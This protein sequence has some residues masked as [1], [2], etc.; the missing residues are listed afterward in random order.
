MPLMVIGTNA[1]PHR[2]YRL[3]PDPK[4]R[5]PRASAKQL[6]PACL[7]ALTSEVV[8]TAGSTGPRKEREKSVTGKKKKK[9]KKR[10]VRYKYFNYMC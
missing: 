3:L 2:Y 1:F 6:V 7:V 8:R 9:K 10:P 4:D 5:W